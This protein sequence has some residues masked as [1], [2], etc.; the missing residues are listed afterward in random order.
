MME[1]I[2]NFFYLEGA[3]L[4]M[5]VIILL[6][7]LYV[8]TRP[9][10]S[11]QA[12]KKGLSIVALFLVLFIGAHYWVTTSRIA[13]VKNAFNA[14]KPVLCESRM[15]RKMAQSIEIRKDTAAHWRIEGDNFVS[16][17]YTRPFHL[18]RCIVK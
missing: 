3:Y 1:T 4:I 18:A 13:A 15:L 8:T 11:A 12:P 17:H 2:K 9:F 5:G 10:M 7:T 6:I 14:G 16:P